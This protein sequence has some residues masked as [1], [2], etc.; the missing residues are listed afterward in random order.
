MKK[1]KLIKTKTWTIVVRTYDNET[2]TMSRTNDGFNLIELLGLAEIM[3]KEI[4]AQAVGLITPDVIER[5]TLIDK[6]NIK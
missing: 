4:H 6:K 2:T 5:K 3:N 1:P